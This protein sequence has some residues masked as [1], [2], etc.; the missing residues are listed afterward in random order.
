MT[1]PRWAPLFVLLALASPAFAQQDR[2]FGTFPALY[3]SLAGVYGDEGPEVT[4]LVQTLSDAL[5]NWVRDG[6]TTEL[7]LRARLKDADAGTA[8][9][10][11]VMLSGLNGE[12]GRLRDA[13]AEIGEAPRISPKLAALHRYR[14]LLYE[15][16]GRP[17]DAAD[18]FRAAWLLDSMDPLNAYRFVVTRSPKT[19]DAEIQQALT[20]LGN[21]ER[22]VVRGQRRLTE[23][24]FL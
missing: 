4:A 2:F 6:N 23:P 11:H 19:S 15:V 14:A 9:Q 5:G 24:P 21:V 18:E 22:E 17:A 8:L 10:I 16:L 12:R 3:R 13:L 7:D 20:T 1:A